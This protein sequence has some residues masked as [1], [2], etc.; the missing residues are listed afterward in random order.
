[1][2]LK[3]IDEGEDLLFLFI[4]IKSL[5]SELFDIFN[6]VF[7]WRKSSNG[8]LVLVFIFFFLNFLL[9][10]Y[11]FVFVIVVSFGFFF[12]LKLSSTF[13]D[14]LEELSD[15]FVFVLALWTKFMELLHQAF[16]TVLDVINLL[17]FIFEF[18][19]DFIDFFQDLT[20]FLSAAS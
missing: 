11:F 5:F 2:G 14:L 4:E 6:L 16:F 15:F 20:L 12:R 8:I 17:L 18:S 19:A 9:F 7:L 13:D 3:L 1:L 10:I